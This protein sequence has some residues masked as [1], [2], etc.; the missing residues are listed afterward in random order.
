LDCMSLADVG[1]FTQIGDLVADRYSCTPV[2]VSHD[3]PR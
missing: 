3:I 2:T 1:G